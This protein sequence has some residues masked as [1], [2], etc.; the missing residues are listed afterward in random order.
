MTWTLG[1]GWT[2][3]ENALHAW[4]STATGLTTSWA[5]QKAPQPAGS[6]AELFVGSLLTRGLSAETRYE[7]DSQRPPAQEGERIQRRPGT[8]VVTAQVY[9]NET[10]GSNCAFARLQ[11]A[12]AALDSPDFYEPLLAAGIGVTGKS[13]VRNLT[14]LLGVSTQG[15]AAVDL[16]LEVRE[17]VTSFVGGVASLRVTSDVT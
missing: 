6:Y 10:V 11:A 15:R 12:V 1:A 17:V 5:W 14:G 4:L 9:T 3:V 16:R 2:E 7:W 8:L 13:E